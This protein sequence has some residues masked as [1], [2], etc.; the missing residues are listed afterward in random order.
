MLKDKAIRF[1]FEALIQKE[2]LTIDVEPR[3]SISKIPN[4][5]EALFDDLRDGVIEHLGIVAD[6]DYKTSKGIGGF[7]KRW[8]QLTLSLKQNKIN[9]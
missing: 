3:H 1:F 2:N 6:A 7:N 5:L 8:Q 4:L 9:K